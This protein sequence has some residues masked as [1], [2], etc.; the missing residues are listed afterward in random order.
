VG[1]ISICDVL[2][3]RLGEVQLEAS[4]LGDYAITARR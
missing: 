2:K 4:V 3:H 1:I